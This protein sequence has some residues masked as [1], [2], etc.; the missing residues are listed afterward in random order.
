MSILLYNDDVNTFLFPF[1][2]LKELRN[3]VDRNQFSSDAIRTESIEHLAE[4]LEMSNNEFSSLVCDNGKF[5]F[6]EKISF[7]YFCNWYN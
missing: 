6:T 2:N 4:V 5:Y 3:F 7:L 1:V